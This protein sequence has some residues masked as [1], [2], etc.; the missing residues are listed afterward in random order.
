MLR[1]LRSRRLAARLLVWTGF[2]AV[3]FVGVSTFFAFKLTGPRSRAIAGP[4]GDFPFAV[5]EVGW[6]TTDDKSIKGW[7]VPGG[8][9]DRAIVL[10]HGFGGDRRQMLPRAKLFRQQGYAVLLYDARACGESSRDC[11]TFGYHEANDLL[12]AIALLK[13]RGLRRIACLGVSQGGATILM[14]AERLGDVRCVICESVFDELAHAVDHRFRRYTLLPGWLAGCVMIPIAEYRTGIGLAEVRPVEHTGKL[15]CPILLIS[16]ER[17]GKARPEEA[18]RLF[19]AAREPKELWLVPNAGHEDL[20][21][22]PDYA[23]RVSEFLN[24]HMRWG[25]PA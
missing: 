25:E 16:G 19:E 18:G 15:P 24:K 7:F 6:T 13:E 5:E 9:G 14:A 10:L 17:D 22:A 11:I 1:L 21:G 2:L 4:P 20:F 8:G 12:G 3:L 23:K